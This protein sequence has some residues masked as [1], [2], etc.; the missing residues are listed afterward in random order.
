MLRSRRWQT[1]KFS[2]PAADTYGTDHK[3][4]FFIFKD[5]WNANALRAQMRRRIARGGME[6]TS[7]SLLSSQKRTASWHSLSIHGLA[8]SKYTLSAVMWLLQYLAL[9]NCIVV[10]LPWFPRLESHGC[11][12]LLAVLHIDV[13]TCNYIVVGTLCLHGA[14]KNDA[15]QSWLWTLSFQLMWGREIHIARPAH[16]ML[17]VSS[18]WYP[19]FR[20]I[21]NVFRCFWIASEVP[22]QSLI[23]TGQ[24]FR[25]L[26]PKKCKV[27]SVWVPLYKTSPFCLHLFAMRPGSV[28]TTWKNLHCTAAL[29]LG[30][31]YP[32]SCTCAGF[33][34]LSKSYLIGCGIRLPSFQPWFAVCLV[35]GK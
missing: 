4:L 34:S 8:K 21:W 11:I 7:S 3:K 29:T 35:P 2:M 15:W 9:L 30:A 18:E 19:C 26:V 17:G 23:A 13:S 24:H 25:F 33:K 6:H 27:C 22:V 1:C 5:A 28:A 14:H 31:V 32:G 10:S 12:V 16:G 20:A